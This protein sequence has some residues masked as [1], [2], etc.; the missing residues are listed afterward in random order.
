MDTF[1]FLKFLAQLAVPP[2]SMAA[3]LVVAAGLALLRWR[4]LARFV[5]AFA[6]V[7]LLALS[8]PPVADA[9][10]APLENEARAAA[11]AAPACCYDAIVVLGGSI[12]PADPPALPE[13]SLTESSDRVWEAARLYH[14]GLAP[15]IIASGGAR[16]QQVDGRGTSEAEA[17]RVFLRDLGV[18][19]AAIVTEEL[20][21]NTLGNVR[22]LR[23]LVKD[24]RVA[25]VTSAYHM[26]R[27]LRLAR[28]A[29]LK[30]EAFPTGW[31][32]GGAQP[33]WEAWLPSIGSLATSGLALREYL[34]QAFDRRRVEAAP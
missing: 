10:I 12:V 21:L 18:P 3:G 30:A 33:P 27:A 19:A 14:R 4:R 9:L 31:R 7:Q 13:P 2:A 8:F 22:H 20:S 26:P 24:N 17:M 29:G 11:A 25:L 34:A 6:V 23:E 15:R 1:V 28:R 32:G 16:D 5:A